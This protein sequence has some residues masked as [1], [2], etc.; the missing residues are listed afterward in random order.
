MFLQHLHSLRVK[1]GA[2]RT[3]LTYEVQEYTVISPNS[4]TWI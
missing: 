2:D 3:K 4:C 1:H